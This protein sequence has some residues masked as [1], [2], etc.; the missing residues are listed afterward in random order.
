[1]EEIDE[2]IVDVPEDELRLSMQFPRRG[3][4]ARGLPPS[5]SSP[6]SREKRGEVIRSD[7]Y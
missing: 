5:E 4:I 6:C 1:M 2:P 7:F 3:S